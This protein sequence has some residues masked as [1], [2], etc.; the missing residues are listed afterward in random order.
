M[1][2]RFWS[3]GGRLWC[4]NGGGLLW[5]GDLG[6]LFGEVTSTWRTSCGGLL[7]GGHLLGDW[8][9]RSCC[10]GTRSGYEMVVIRQELGHKQNKLDLEYPETISRVT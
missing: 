5:G 10:P 6:N 7:E 4:L 8:L 1:L 3:P 9:P 2:P